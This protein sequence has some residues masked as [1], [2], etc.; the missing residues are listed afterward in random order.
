[1]IEYRIMDIE[2]ALGEAVVG[3]HES[4]HW[5]RVQMGIDFGVNNSEWMRDRILN[6]AATYRHA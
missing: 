6:E 4:R 3:G 5:W 2:E 1:M